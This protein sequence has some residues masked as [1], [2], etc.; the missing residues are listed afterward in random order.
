[1]FV[2][3][4]CACYALLK[5]YFGCT[6]LTNMIYNFTIIMCGATRL[7]IVLQVQ[8]LFIGLTL[9]GPVISGTCKAVK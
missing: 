7:L 5:Q 4:C 9:S 8:L 6:E 2:S 1:M 3:F